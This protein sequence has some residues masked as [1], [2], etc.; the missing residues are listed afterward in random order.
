MNR[1]KPKMK[2]RVTVVG[3]VIIGVLVAEVIFLVVWLVKVM[4]IIC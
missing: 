1:R 2:R 4:P 3:A